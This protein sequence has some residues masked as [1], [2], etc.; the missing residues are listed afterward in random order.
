MQ[1]V[2]QLHSHVR[3][4]QRLQQLTHVNLTQPDAIQ[5]DNTRHARRGVEG[6]LDE[7]Q[8]LRNA[9]AIDSHGAVRVTAQSGIG[10][11]ELF[12]VWDGV[13]KLNELA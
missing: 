2:K 7:M 1:I 8:R 11:D 4:K 9:L 5:H 12:Q 10:G 3:S 13:N 6:Q